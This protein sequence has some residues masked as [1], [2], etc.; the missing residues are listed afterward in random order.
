MLN[1]RLVQ[2]TKVLAGRGMIGKLPALLCDAGFSK[3][4]LV[5]DKGV[6]AAGII[7]RITDI[8]SRAGYSYHT[9]N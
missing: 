1:Y 4:C 2:K 5:Y 7:K 9:Y 8:L 6:E 3:P